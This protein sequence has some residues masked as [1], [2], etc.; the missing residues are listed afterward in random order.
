M[1]EKD[2]ASMAARL[3]TVLEVSCAGRCDDVMQGLYD[4]LMDFMKILS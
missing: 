3:C 2:G 4:V 1:G